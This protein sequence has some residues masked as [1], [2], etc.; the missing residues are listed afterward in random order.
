MDLIRGFAEYID[1]KNLVKSG[2]SILL[3]VSGGPDSLA[4]LDLF[5]RIKNKLKL[6]LVVF[7]LNHKFRREA[8]QEAT[9]VSRTAE[10]YQLKAIIEEYDVPG[11]IEEKGLSPEEAAREIRFQLLFKWAGKLKINKIALAHNRDDLVETIF[12]NL[13]RGTGLK[14]LTGIDPLTEINNLEIIHPLLDISRKDIEK[15]CH[16]RGLQ[17]RYDPTNEETLYTRN[18]IRHK[19]IPYLEKEINP[20]LKEVIARMAE[21]IREEDCFLREL[22]KRNLEE[23]LIEKRG[24]KIVLSLSGLKEIPRVIRRR[25]FRMVISTLKGD[26]VDLYSYHYQAIDD[27]ILTGSTGKMIDLKDNL[28]V[29]RLYDQL[30]FDQNGFTEGYA[31]FNFKLTVPGEVN[32]PGDRVL[33]AETSPYFTGWRKLAL[34]PEICLC[35]AD[36]VKPPLTVRNR[37][38]GDRFTPLG[39]KGVKKLKDFFIDE[40]IP[41][42]ERNR[43]PLVL[44]STGKIIWIAGLRIDDRFKVTDKTERFL[45]LHLK[46]D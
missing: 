15:Y 10:R 39:M 27:L 45:K 29:K 24:N 23:V 30:I 20:G 33:K 13:V 11:Y 26:H 42:R 16:I 37:R 3:G 6:K 21:I 43:I 41:E 8:G 19:V 14:G 32:L 4:M 9:F 25:I 22:A 2:D 18:K 17:P 46:G 44:D 31:E 40:K 38:P 35:D 7:H 28:K 12:L 34:K 1:E 5:S 36:K